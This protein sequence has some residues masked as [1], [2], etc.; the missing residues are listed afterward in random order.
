MAFEYGRNDLR[1]AALLKDAQVTAVFQ[2]RQT[3][4]Q[5]QAITGEPKPGV[6]ATDRIHLPM[7]ACALLAE[8]QVGRLVQQCF[9]INARV[10]ADQLHLDEVGLVKGF[11]AFECQDLKVIFHTLQDKFE[12]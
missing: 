11:A 8:A 4:C 5:G 1:H 6:I 2:P 12:T 9:Q 10:F 3:R 7:Q